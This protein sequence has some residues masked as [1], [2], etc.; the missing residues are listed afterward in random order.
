MRKTKIA[1]LIA[2]ASMFALA[3]NA[4]GQDMDTWNWSVRSEIGETGESFLRRHAA[5]YYYDIRAD[6]DMGVVI[7][8]PQRVLR[9]PRD[10]SRQEII[11][12]IRD[13][14]HHFLCLDAHIIFVVWGRD[15]V[16]VREICDVGYFYFF[17]TRRF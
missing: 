15:T 12:A 6:R 10:P 17:L 11:S 7:M 2:L 5:A 16:L 9:I 8:L 13:H 3:G 1:L 14:H 4:Y